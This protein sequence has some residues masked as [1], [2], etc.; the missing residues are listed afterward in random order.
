M[1][2]K[3]YRNL[4]TATF[5]LLLM[6]SEA[7]SQNTPFNSGFK[8]KIEKLMEQDKLHEADTMFTLAEKNRSI[9]TYDLMK[10][11]RIKG[12]LADY[13]EIGRIACLIVQRQPGLSS[14]I[15][16]Q[17]PEIIKDAEPITIRKVMEQ[18]LF[19]AL[20]KNDDATEL[21]LWAAD[22]YSRFGLYKEE[23]DI[24]TDPALKNQDVA[25]AL[26]NSANKKFAK[27]LFIPAINAALPSYQLFNDP[28]LKSICAMILFQSYG[29]IGKNDSAAIWLGR[30]SFAQAGFKISAAA[31]FQKTGYF[32]KADSIIA[33]IP[34]SLSR[35]TL[36]IRQLLYKGEIGA[37]IDLSE[38][39]RFNKY[40]AQEKNQ[41]LFWKMRSLFFGG[42]YIEAEAL[43]DSIVFFPSMSNANTYVNTKYIFNNIKKEPQAG[44]IFGSLAY[45]I[46]L[47]K[48]DDIY[49]ILQSG[50]I[51][52]Y[53]PDV[54]QLLYCEGIKALI[55]WKQ[56]A[57]TLTLIEQT[58][59]STDCPELKF[60]YGEALLYTGK[61]EKGRAVLEEHLLEYPGNVFSEKARL[62][63]NNRH[64]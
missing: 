49:K 18:Y 59:I 5:L 29:H 54:K 26:L 21:K 14:F 10:W 17:L 11:L 61:I 52:A 64:P 13:A 25:N 35:D 32:R 9:D 40:N 43:Q 33:L 24:L 27:K 28:D 23:L 48:P 55:A 47:D 57:P 15:C 6:F 20:V 16:D 58:K 31:F 56:F 12:V 19:C 38:S 44:K 53:Y 3:I 7:S 8:D 36:M 60:Y 51:S 34:A 4:Y 30:T 2:C 41:L 39:L 42:R 50:A 37:A 22:V 46:W 63:L 45:G 1:Y 62:F